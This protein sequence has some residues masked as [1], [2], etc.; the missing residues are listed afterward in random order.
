[1]ARPMNA[2]A[3]EQAMAVSPHDEFMAMLKRVLDA[4][5]SVVDINKDLHAFASAQHAAELLREQ[6]EKSLGSPTRRFAGGG[7]KVE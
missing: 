2:N 4:V 6:S 5:L 3:A 7:L 1:M